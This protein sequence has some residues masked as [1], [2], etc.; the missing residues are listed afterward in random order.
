MWGAHLASERDV[1]FGSHRLRSDLWGSPEFARFA[2]ILGRASGVILTPPVVFALALATSFVVAFA[3]AVF[4][5]TLR[6]VARPVHHRSVVLA[7]AEWYGAGR[8]G[9]I[10]M[11]LA[12]A[13]LAAQRVRS[14]SPDLTRLTWSEAAMRLTLVH[15]CIGRRRGQPYIRTWQMEPLAPATLA[16][17][18]PRDATSRSASTTI[19]WKRSRTTSRPISSRSASRPTPR[20]AAYQI[21]SEYPPA[22]R[23]GRHGRISP[24]AGARRSRASTPRRSSSA[25]RKACGP[26]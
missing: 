24:D 8:L 18:T 9:A 22:R 14:S 19:A 20:S 13:W 23:A 4:P 12:F 11:T 6:A 15:P 25:K 21:A 26:A 7:L 3:S 5:T 1:Q 16:G 17:L 2:G 10:I